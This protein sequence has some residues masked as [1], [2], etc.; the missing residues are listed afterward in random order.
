MDLDAIAVSLHTAAETAVA[1]PQ[2]CAG[3]SVA[4]G[5]S[6]QRQVVDLRDEPRTGVKLGL[7]SRAK[8]AQ[9]GVSDVIIGQLT[10][11]MAVPDGGRVAAV[12]FIHPR[13]EPEVAFLL[14]GDDIVAVAPALEI[15]D[16]RFLDFKFDLVDVIA[17]NTSASAYVL[18]PWQPPDI[19]IGNRGVVLEVDGV[20]VETGST[21]A[22]LGDPRRAPATAVRLAHTHGVPT[23]DNS[24]LLAGAAT[25]AVALKPGSVVEARIS[26]LGRVSVTCSP[27]EARR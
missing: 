17:D 25:A 24:I 15:I 20:V 8:A 7:T 26:G 23:P 16:S 10:A 14:H 3:L 12:R 18:G 27:E 19:D 11:G 2:R 22:I 6:I 13:I 1:I 9:V 5:Y 21:A 4:D